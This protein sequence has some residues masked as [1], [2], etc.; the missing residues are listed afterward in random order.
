VILTEPS[1]CNAQDICNFL[2]GTMILNEARFVH[3]RFMGHCFKSLQDLGL[4]SLQDKDIRQ[5]YQCILSLKAF[6]S[7]HQNHHILPFDIE[8]SWKT[9]WCVRQATSPLPR[10]VASALAV[11]REMGYDTKDRFL[12]QGMINTSV[13][14]LKDGMRYS[15]EGVS[16]LRSF[17]NEPTQPIARYFWKV[18]LLE[19]MGF[20]VI[21]IDEREWLSLKDRSA[22]IAHLELKIRAVRKSALDKLI[23]LQRKVE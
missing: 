20:H 8:M 7:L 23:F 9:N 2:W 21:A 5:F 14:D 1:K 3:P 16:I 19:T 17:R 18:R 6:R 12:E 15:V 4:S 11:L 10:W 13:V 22:Q